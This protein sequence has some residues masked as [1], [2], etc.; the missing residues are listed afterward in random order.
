MAE[1]FTIEEIMKLYAYGYITI[2]A[3]GE[4]EI[5]KK[6]QEEDVCS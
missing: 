1:R 4:I 6:E 5:I 3:G 2:C